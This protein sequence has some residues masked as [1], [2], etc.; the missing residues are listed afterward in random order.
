MEGV[1]REELF[2]ESLAEEN[3][4]IEIGEDLACGSAGLRFIDNTI[5]AI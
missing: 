3:S 2:G 5:F 4:L 1:F